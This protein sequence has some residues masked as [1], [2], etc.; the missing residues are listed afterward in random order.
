MEANTGDDLDGDDDC[1]GEVDDET[2]R[3]P[4]ASIRDEMRAVLPEILEAM[5]D[6]CQAAM[7]WRSLP[8]LR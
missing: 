5:P 2:K 7:E 8:L 6:Q 1:C 3:R 4:P